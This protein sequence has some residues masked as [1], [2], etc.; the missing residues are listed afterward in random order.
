MRAGLKTTPT[1]R[2]K[3]TVE[4]ASHKATPKSVRPTA[5]E[6]GAIMGALVF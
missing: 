2:G 6:R 4:K 5:T 3:T 1:V